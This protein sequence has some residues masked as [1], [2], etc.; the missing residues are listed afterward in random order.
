MW[1]GMRPTFVP[2]VILIHPAVLPQQTWAENW[3][4][5]TLGRESW[6]HNV[7]RAGAYLHA[8]FR[9]DPSNR[10]AT[11]HQR[12]TGQTGQTDRQTDRQRIDSI[13]RTVLQTFAQKCHVY[14]GI[15]I[16]TYRAS[17]IFHSLSAFV[18]RSRINNSVCLLLDVTR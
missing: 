1:P 14:R 17:L 2:S 10:L 9:L 15:F 7:V 4:F 12:Q 13:V 3:G 18:A 16:S 6:E 8:K 11:I 5:A